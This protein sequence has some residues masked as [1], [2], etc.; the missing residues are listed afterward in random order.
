MPAR[1]R[2]ERGAWGAAL[3]KLASVLVLVVV[4][5]VALVAAGP[6]LTRLVTA[7]VP[8][9]LVAGIVVAVLRLVWSYTRKW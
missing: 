6:T 4:G 8:L 1:L 5:L 2:H 7:F 9:V 3:S